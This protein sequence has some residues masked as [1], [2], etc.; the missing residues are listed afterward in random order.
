M[1]R[2][3]IVIDL[4]VLAN[5][6]ANSEGVCGAC[7]LGKLYRTSFPSGGVKRA[8]RNSRKLELIHIDVCGIMDSESLRKNKY[9]MLFIDDLTRMT[10]VYFLT[11]KGQVYLCLKNSKL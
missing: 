1:Q 2:S 4:P 3:G 8:S 5:V 7:Q 6:L 9:F 10:W 11:N